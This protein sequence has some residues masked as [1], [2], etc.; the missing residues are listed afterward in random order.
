M[1]ELD[2]IGQKIAL[3]TEGNPELVSEVIELATIKLKDAERR[4][5]GA[6]PHKLALLAL[7]DLC[8]EYIRSKKRFQENRQNLTTRSEQLIELIEA[9]LN[10]SRA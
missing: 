3:K 4:G 7:L 9:E 6:P 5:K 1:L 2:F 8:E 10:E